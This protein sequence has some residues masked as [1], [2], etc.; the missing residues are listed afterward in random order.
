MENSTILS[1]L[2]A[3]DDLHDLKLETELATSPDNTYL[4]LLPQTVH[5]MALVPNY[6]QPSITPV[7]P[8]DYEE[9]RVNPNLLSFT[10]DMDL[11][12]LTLNFDEPVNVSSLE[13]HW[14]HVVV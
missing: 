4:Q 7:A 10:V 6:V 13:F 9:D 11:G 3:L 14:P 2:L 5:D 12:Q 1:L 8:E